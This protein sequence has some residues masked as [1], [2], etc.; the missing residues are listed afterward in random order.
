M[1]RGWEA[2]A[3][4]EAGKVCGASCAA[5]AAWLVTSHCHARQLAPSGR[6]GPAPSLRAH[7]RPALPTLCR[8][9]GA[10]ARG[11]PRLPQAAAAQDLHLWQGPP[12]LTLA[13]PGR[14]HSASGA[15][16]RMRAQMCTRFP[17]SPASPTLVHSVLKSRGCKHH[18]GSTA[19]WV[20]L[21]ALLPSSPPLP[22]APTPV[23][24]C[25]LHCFLSPCAQVWIMAAQFEIRQLRLDAARKILGMAIGMC[26]KVGARPAQ[27]PPPASTQPTPCL[28]SKRG[29]PSAMPR[30]PLH[31]VPVETK[32]RCAAS[33]SC[34][35][36]A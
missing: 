10:R 8:G 14:A 30:M 26:P 16:C 33:S 1:S 5:C 11:V 20:L 24:T 22:S 6:A 12:A 35:M 7:P 18:G 13:S 36:S 23:T 4:G 17:V 15:R 31:R 9:H 21:V 27:P 29:S 3:G 34:T 32:L 19:P 2:E 28:R 25:L